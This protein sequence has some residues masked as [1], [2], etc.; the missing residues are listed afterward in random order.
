MKRSTSIVVLGLFLASFAFLADG[1][2]SKEDKK[3]TRTL[4]GTIEELDIPG[5]TVTMN[6]F[7]EKLGKSMIIAGK[8]TKETEIYI[9]GKLG[10]LSHVKSG[11]KVIVEGYKKGTDIIAVKVNITQVGQATKINRPTTQPAK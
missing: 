7:N 4:K 5:N 8:I 2:K 3:H 10:K 6:W 9:D 11:D 1:C